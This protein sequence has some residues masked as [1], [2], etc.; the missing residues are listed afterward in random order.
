MFVATVVVAQGLRHQLTPQ[1]TYDIATSPKTLINCSLAGP[2]PTTF[3]YRSLSLVRLGYLIFG[4][5]SMSAK[6]FKE[7]KD[8]IKTRSPD[9]LTFHNVDQVDFDHVVQGL[10]HRTNYLEQYAFRIHWFARE[11]YLKVVMPSTLHECAGQWVYDEISDALAKGIIPQVWVRKIGISASPEYKNFI[12]QYQ[13]CTKEADLTFVPLLG[14]NWTEK[15]KYPSVVLE[16]GWSEAAEQLNQDA[17]LWQAGSGGQV[18]VVIQVKFYKRQDRIGAHVRV[19]RAKAAKDSSIK[20]SIET[21]EVLPVPAVLVENPSITFEEFF[22]GGC[23]PGMDPKGC[24]VL[25]L[26]NLRVIARREILDRGGVP[27]E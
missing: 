13:G 8:A 6:I 12:G 2:S 22:A 5:M 1:L 9:F 3:I 16:S 17:S 26:E 23:P 7:I 19:N 25:D 18:R 11:K 4:C 14:P 15:A 24:V 20:T 21:Y 27:D 10:R